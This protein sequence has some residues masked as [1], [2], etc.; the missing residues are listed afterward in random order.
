MKT[1]AGVLAVGLV[2]LVGGAAAAA[3]NG[4][5]LTWQADPATSMAVSWNSTDPADGHIAFGTDPAALTGTAAATHTAQ[6]VPLRHSFTALLTGLEPDTT[7]YYRVAGYPAGEPL[8]F[9]TAPA[10]SCA[11]GGCGCQAGGSSPAGLVLLGLG[12]LALR[13]RRID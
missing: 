4:V 8:S 13:R 5:R 6:P 7:Y 9:R 11:A 2:V 1:R 3:P 12:F 10:D